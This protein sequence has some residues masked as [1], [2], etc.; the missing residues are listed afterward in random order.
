MNKSVQDLK[1][2]IEVIKKTNSGNSG[3]GKFRKVNRNYSHK[4]YEENTRNGRK[5]LR[6]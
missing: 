6:Q 4:H 5:N 3:N 1:M 2:E